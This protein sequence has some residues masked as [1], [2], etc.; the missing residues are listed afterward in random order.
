VLVKGYGAQW[1]NLYVSKGC[2][3]DFFFTCEPGVMYSYGL[4][5]SNFTHNISIL[6]FD[7]RVF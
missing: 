3:Q 4:F 5:K 2:S 6:I 1:T 7:F